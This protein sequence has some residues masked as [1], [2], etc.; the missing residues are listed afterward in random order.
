MRRR[1][2]SFPLKRAASHLFFLLGKTPCHAGIMWP[3]EFEMFFCQLRYFLWRIFGWMQRQKYVKNIRVKI[4]HL[5]LRLTAFEMRHN[6]TIFSSRAKKLTYLELRCFVFSKGVVHIKPVKFDLFEMQGSVNK[7][8]G[9]CKSI[10]ISSRSSRTI[11]SSRRR[12]SS[13]TSS[14]TKSK[15]RR[16]TENNYCVQ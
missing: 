5:E 2:I 11:A 7:H 14:W 13:S 4:S 15:K 16:K 12:S 1:W 8:S 3:E 6:F 10:S 9:K